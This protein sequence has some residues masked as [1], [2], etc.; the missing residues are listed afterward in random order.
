VL[1]T[2]EPI[3]TIASASYSGSCSTCHRQ[4]DEA[5]FDANT[6]PGALLAAWSALR[7][8]TT[9]TVEGGAQV[10]ADAFVQISAKRRMQATLA[11]GRRAIGAA[12]TRS[13][14]A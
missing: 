3:W 8:W 10:P 7:A 4:P 11:Q 12:L 2:R 1:D 5:H 14:T 9:D 6:W 13:G